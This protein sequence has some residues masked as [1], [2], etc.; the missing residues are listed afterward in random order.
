MS[1]IAVLEGGESKKE[2]ECMKDCAIRRA[3]VCAAAVLLMGGC[4]LFVP[5]DEELISSTMVRW[6]RA[7]VAKDVDKMMEVYSEEFVSGDGNDK[8]AVRE[9]VEWAIDEGYLEGIEVDLENAEMGIEDE[10]ATFDPVELKFI[11]GDR[12][13]YGYTL[14]KEKGDWLIVRSREY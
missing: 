14:R 13:R 10:E 4:Q 2:S 5:S 11:N 7:L 3:V 12:Q 8:E 1:Y 9:I 6:K